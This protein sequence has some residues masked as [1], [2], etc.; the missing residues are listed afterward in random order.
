MVSMEPTG[1]WGQGLQ[2]GWRADLRKNFGTLDSEE[3]RY[4][5]KQEM[6]TDRERHENG[7]AEGVRTETRDND[8]KDRQERD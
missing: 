5:D 2:E 1:S 6:E 3:Q 4:A 8:V 7:K